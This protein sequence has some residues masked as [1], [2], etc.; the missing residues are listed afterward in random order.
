MSKILKE[1]NNSLIRDL[2]I[3]ESAKN[4]YTLQEIPLNSVT[5]K[6]LKE[7]LTLESFDK[8]FRQMYDDN[9]KKEPEE[10]EPPKKKSKSQ[11]SKRLKK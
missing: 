9:N 8:K 4:N 6:F 1:G 11:K 3:D 2:K 5:K 7:P 10:P